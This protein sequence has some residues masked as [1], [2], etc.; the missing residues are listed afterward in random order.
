MTLGDGI[1]IDLVSEVTRTVEPPSDTKY[2]QNTSLPAGTQQSTIKARK[3][4]EVDTYQ[5]WYKNGTEIDRKLLCHS[6]YRAYQATIEY[7]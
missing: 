5:V 3:G 2:V 4:Y 1:T 6:T 7:N